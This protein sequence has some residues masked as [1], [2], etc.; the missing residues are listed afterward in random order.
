MRKAGP[1]PEGSAGSSDQL[2]Q[3]GGH[4]AQSKGRAGNAAPE[5]PR[6]RPGSGPP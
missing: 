6:G 1:P 5:A 3:V 2:Q 4:E